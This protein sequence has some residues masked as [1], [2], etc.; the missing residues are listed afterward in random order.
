[1]QNLY[2]R[3]D[4][5]QGDADGATNSR[6]GATGALGNLQ[7]RAEHFPAAIN[8]GSERLARNLS[9]AR[10]AARVVH[11]RFGGF[12]KSGSAWGQAPRRRTSR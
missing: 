5:N 2:G 4:L 10:V 3:S 9:A 11:D 7:R 1:M 8:C 12:W 6:T